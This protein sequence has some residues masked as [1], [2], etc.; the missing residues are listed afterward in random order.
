MAA[1]QGVAP[2]LRVELSPLGVSDAAEIERAIAAFAPRPN[3]G[4]ILIPTALTF[5]HRQLDHRS[6]GALPITGDLS[7]S[8]LRHRW[9]ADLLRTRRDRAV[10]A[11]GRLRRPYPQGRETGRATGAGADKVREVIN[12]KTAKALGLDIPATIY[13]RADEVIE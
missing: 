12:L 9:R 3:G 8:V 2:G 5:I 11:G 13:A 10:S 4:M 6:R 1:M 7:L